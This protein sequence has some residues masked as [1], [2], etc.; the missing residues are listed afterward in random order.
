MFLLRL[1]LTLF[2]FSMSSDESERFSG[3]A[4][5]GA[6]SSFLLLAGFLARLTAGSALAVG[7]SETAGAASCVAG[8]ASVF[9]DSTGAASAFAFFAFGFSGFGSASFSGSAMILTD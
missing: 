7:G 4:A 8:A 5:V 2:G 1:A 9:S 6:V 3:A